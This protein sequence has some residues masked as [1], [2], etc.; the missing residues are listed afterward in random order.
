[1]KEKEITLEIN[2]KDY[3]VKIHR[4]SADE[5][6]ISVDDTLYRVGLKDLG[7][8]EVAQVKPQPAPRGPQATAP[9]TSLTSRPDPTLHRPKEI[10]DG[11]FIKAPLPGL[12]LKV[13]VNKGDIIKAGQ[14]MMIIEAMKMENEVTSRTDGQVL[15]VRFKEGDSVNQG[16]TLILLK[17]VEG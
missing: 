5:A 17:P 1:M 9:K 3:R 16:D 4:F 14:T 13:L 10:S 7:I 2:G 11:T 8:E 12:V 15:D 6:E